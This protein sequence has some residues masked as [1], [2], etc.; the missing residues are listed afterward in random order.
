MSKVVVGGLFKRNEVLGPGDEALIDFGW[1]GG[2]EESLGAV[3]GLS[4]NMEDSPRGT[5]ESC[6]SVGSTNDRIGGRVKALSGFDE[7]F[8]ISVPIS[9]GRGE[10][11]WPFGKFTELVNG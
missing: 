9:E 5:K 7:P 2:D 11:V 1:R 3:K 4:F 8:D 10:N 6:C